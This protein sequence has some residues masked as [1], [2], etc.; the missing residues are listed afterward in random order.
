MNKKSNKK[1]V[2]IDFYNLMNILFNRIW[3]IIA[4]VLIG[5]LIG[6]IY[7]QNYNNDDVS[8]RLQFRIDEI[9]K[10]EQLQIS[11]FNKNL[12]TLYEMK[13]EKSVM[14]Y[15]SPNDV[16]QSQDIVREMDKFIKSKVATAFNIKEKT[17]SH[18]SKV[19]ELKSADLITSAFQ[20]SQKAKF[21]SMMFNKYNDYIKENFSN[22]QKKLQ[23]LSLTNPPAFGGALEVI[24]GYNSYQVEILF[25]D[26]VENEMAEIYS[27]ILVEELIFQMNEQIKHRYELAKKNYFFEINN[28]LSNIDL[29]IN[30]IKEEYKIAINRKLEKLRFQKDIAM[31]L[32]YT[33]PLNDVQVSSLDDYYKKGHL[34]LDKEIN[35]LQ[36]RLTSDFDTSVS[37]VRFYKNAKGFINE[38]VT[39]NRVEEIVSEIGIL[40]NS[41]I[42]FEIS[43]KK[44]KPTIPSFSYLK[45]QPNNLYAIPFSALLGLIIGIVIVVNSHLSR[46]RNDKNV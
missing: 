19:P 32:G 35:V 3:V 40:D 18:L 27:K 23:L 26:K 2:E 42:P 34:Y 30:S 31:E 15:Q 43:Y 1:L 16:R 20:V 4:F 13:Y 37:E 6:Y 28:I 44:N 25:N 24:N 46:S 11:E 41:F 22:D 10:I 12:L 5:V 29:L 8:Y 39:L 7:S 14:Q 36:E 38:N 45:V 21:E 9:N 17:D 33:R